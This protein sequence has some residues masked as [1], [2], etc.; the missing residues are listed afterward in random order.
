MRSRSS[1]ESVKIESLDDSVMDMSDPN[2]EPST[3]AKSIAV[4]ATGVALDAQQ[5][6]KCSVGK[7]DV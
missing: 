1:G 3:S 4:E 6:A 2:T 5:R 7:S